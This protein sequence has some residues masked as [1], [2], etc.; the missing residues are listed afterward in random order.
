VA[1]AGNNHALYVVRDEPHR[2]RGRLANAFCSA[3]G[4]DGQGKP[5]GLA[6]LVLRDGGIQR[7]VGRK[8]PSRTIGR[9][10][11]SPQWRVKSPAMKTSSPVP[12]FF[13]RR[14]GSLAML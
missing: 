3:D 1:A 10:R 9:F 13:S 4:Q 5:P 11:V 12:M 14:T 7:A 2:V 8:E 6:L